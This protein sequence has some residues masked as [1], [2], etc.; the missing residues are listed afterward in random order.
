MRQVARKSLLTV[1]AAGGM[2]VAGGGYAHADSGALGGTTHSP[3]VLSGNTV[4]APVHVPVNLCGNTVNVVGLL[5]PATGNRCATAA[6]GSR[7]STGGAQAHG[8]SRHSPGVGSGNTVQI[9]VDV[10]VNV[11]G[12]SVSV[13]G[14]GNAV[15][16]NKC[17]DEQNP[18]KPGH[19]GHPGKPGHPGHPGKPGHPGHPGKPGHPGHPGKPGHPGHPGHPGKPG[20]PGHPGKPGEPGTPG[21][22]GQPGKPGTPGN[23]GTP[24]KPGVPSTPSSPAPGHVVTPA[25]HQVLGTSQVN[26]GSG[27]L[28]HTGTEGT[29]GALAPAAAALLL[30]GT[31]LYRRGRAA[32]R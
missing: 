15:T 28:A 19:P 17:T 23:P 5:N 6:S 30:G 18:G 4:Q 14:L 10:P 21:K 22:P 31:V 1:A 2:L 25:T 11:C 29:V 32:R 16:G 13:V 20:H 7:G 12:N 3:G 27:Q 8:G 26:Q 9:P 24:G